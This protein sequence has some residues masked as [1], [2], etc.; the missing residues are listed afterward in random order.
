METVAGEA[1]LTETHET[2]EA[3]TIS[4]LQQAHAMSHRAETTAESFKLTRT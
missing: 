4:A 2:V 3:L 1:V